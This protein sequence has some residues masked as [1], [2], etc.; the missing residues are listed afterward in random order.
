MQNY[1]N[2]KHNI[3]ANTLLKLYHENECEAQNSSKHKKQVLSIDFAKPKLL[4]KDYEPIALQSPCS[5]SLL[6]HNSNF[7]SDPAKRVHFTNNNSALAT[8]K[9]RSNL[10]SFN[11]NNPHSEHASRVRLTQNNRSLA[12]Q[13]FNQNFIQTNCMKL[14]SANASQVHLT[15][16]Q[17]A[18]AHSFL[19]PKVNT[20]N[21]TNSNLDF[22]SR[23]RFPHNKVTPA[24]HNRLLIDKQ[25][26]SHNL[27][28]S[29]ATH[30]NNYQ[31]KSKFA[32]HNQHTVN[33]PQKIEPQIASNTGKAPLAYQNQSQFTKLNHFNLSINNKPQIPTLLSTQ[34]SHTLNNSCAQLTNNK[35]LLS[36]QTQSE[37][38]LSSPFSIN[39]IQKSTTSSKMSQQVSSMKSKSASTRSN[40]TSPR[41]SFTDNTTTN[42]PR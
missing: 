17:F 28:A 36:A 9:H 2:K 27:N 12:A 40:R 7:V 13:K 14:T 31:I 3:S 42:S 4:P 23:V 22:A 35:K 11:I 24:G 6:K 37:I 39:L 16:N 38:Q 26:I 5:K 19:T 10:P 20:L 33:T 1:S 21:F 41:N 32:P 15:Q 34:K 8:R 30:T 18:F 25:Y 29:F